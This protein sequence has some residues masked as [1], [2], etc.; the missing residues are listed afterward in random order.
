V[1]HLEGAVVGSNTAVIP[2]M[3]KVEKIFLMLGFP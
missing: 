3:K 1:V 2:A